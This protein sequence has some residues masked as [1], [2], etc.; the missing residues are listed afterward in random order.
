MPMAFVAPSEGGSRIK[1]ADLNGHLCV[2]EPKEYKASVTTEYGTSPAI[3]T[4]IHDLETGMSHIGHLN[5]NV[6]IVNALKDQIGQ[7][8][9]ARIGQGSATPGKSAPWELQNVTAEP[10][11]MARALAWQ[12]GNVPAPVATPPAFVPAS[13]ATALPNINDPAIAALLASLGAKPV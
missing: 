3:E 13:S 6:K 1:I 8:V 5:F 12:A 9:L 4:D 11:A 2:F 7:Q 10:A